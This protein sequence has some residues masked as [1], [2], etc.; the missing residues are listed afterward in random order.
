ML[1]PVV[2][3]LV[4]EPP[5]AELSSALL[6][7][8]SRALEDA[9]CLPAPP[10]TEASTPPAEQPLLAV[11]AFED[12]GLVTI[13]LGNHALGWT[14]RRLHFGAADALSD[15]YTAVGYTTGTIARMRLNVDED[16]PAAAPASSSASSGADEDAAAPPSLPP[17][18]PRSAGFR[19]TRPTSRLQPAVAFGAAT[20]P[21]RTLGPWRTGGWLQ[22]RAEQDAAWFFGPG[23]RYQQAPSGDGVSF[24]WFDLGL[25]AGR[26]LHIKGPLSAYL[27]LGLEGER[28]AITARE[29][30]TARQEQAARWF[31]VVRPATELGVAASPS[32]DL[33]FGVDLVLTTARTDAT[34][35]GR[36]IAPEPAVPW[37]GR[38]GVRWLP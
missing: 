38:V 10:A 20:G 32:V 4:A 36:R 1:P 13:R 9:P 18:A 33:L 30:E 24:D 34:V 6:R 12:G 22:L 7:A 26:R 31:A 37:Q 28:I 2:V 29:S 19:E 11:I 21:A 17:P 15:V 5:A 3:D 16:P 27:T 8:C 23:A 14:T 25:Y 35:S